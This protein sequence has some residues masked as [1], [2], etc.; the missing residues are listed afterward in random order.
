[1]ANAAAATAHSG[2]HD[3]HTVDER[4]GVN[5]FHRYYCASRGWAHLVQTTLVPAV[6]QGTELGRRVLEIGPGPGLT[7]EVLAGTA[8]ELTAIEIDP[9]LAKATHR[10]VPAARI[11]QADATRMP[12]ADRTFS[13]V[14]CLTM[15]HHLPVPELQDRLFAE[16]HRVLVPGGVFCGSDN[17]GRGL[18][19]RLIHLGDNRTIVDPGTLGGRLRDAGFEQARIRTGSRIVFHAHRPTGELDRR[20]HVP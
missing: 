11:V 2:C 13:A 10:R 4:S 14:V 8:P 18:K 12:F 16:V 15:L 19:F 20:A 7:T 3:G 17:P 6:L 1:M 5:R 9:K